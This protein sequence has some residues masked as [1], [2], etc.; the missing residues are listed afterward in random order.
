MIRDDSPRNRGPVEHNRE[1]A[2]T[3]RLVFEGA[4]SEALA[5]RAL[6]DDQVHI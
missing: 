2:G 4:S 3:A 1:I 5:A 6:N